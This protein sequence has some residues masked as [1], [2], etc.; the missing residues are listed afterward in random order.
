MKEDL[1]RR[2]MLRAAAQR[3][4]LLAQH[5]QAS[6]AISMAA[7]VADE[8]R[9]TPIGGEARPSAWSEA[10]ELRLQ[11]Q[12]GREAYL[13]LMAATEE[14]LLQELQRHAREPAGAAQ[15]DEWALAQEYE[16]YLLSEDERFTAQGEV[17]PSES[18]LEILCPLCVAAPLKQTADGCV[19]CS[20]A[21]TGCALH[22]DAR[23]HPAPL[24]LLR[25]RMDTLLREHS[26]RCAGQACCRLPLPAER[27]LGM[28]LFCCPA[29]G[30]ATG[31]V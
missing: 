29:C 2:C 1:R 24:E 26:Q 14:S 22:L 8:L 18:P 16:D 11:A 12:L 10:D 17:M 3:Q 6:E 19:T 23:G 27:S 31:V 5:R 21:A 4:A 15:N 25:E 7:L 28:L 9:R 13:E 30:V 20:A